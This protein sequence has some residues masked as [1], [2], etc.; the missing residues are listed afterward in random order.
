[1]SFPLSAPPRYEMVNKGYQTAAGFTLAADKTDA[2]VAQVEPRSSADRAGL[3]AGDVILQ[4]DGAPLSGEQ[5][6][7]PGLSP[8]DNLDQY[9]GNFGSW[10]R[11][12]ND[13][14]LVVRGSD[15]ATRTMT[16]WPW[17]LRLHPTQLY[18]VVSMFLL[19]LLLT[20]YYPFRRHDGQVIAL[21]M[22]CYAVHRYLNE[23][24]RADERPVGFE[25]WTSVVLFVAGVGLWIWLWTRPA[26]Y[27][28]QTREI[29]APLLK[30]AATTSHPAAT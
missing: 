27:R 3:K 28:P 22:I 16:L 24:L 29:V 14:T 15:G 8:V 5:S 7:F 30:S 13:L 6:R 18:E 11:G 19:F 2:I 21:L 17:T 25:S 20:A 9:M 10:P 1:V 26:Q 4:A 23:M 12:K